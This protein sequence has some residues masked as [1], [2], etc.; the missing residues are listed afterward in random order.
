[1]IAVREYG[2]LRADGGTIEIG[3]NVRIGLEPT[4]IIIANTLVWMAEVV[5]PAIGAGHR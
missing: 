2:K 3:S 4:H 5:E 1:M